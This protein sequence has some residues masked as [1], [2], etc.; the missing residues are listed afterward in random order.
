MMPLC[1]CSIYLCCYAIV[2]CVTFFPLQCSSTPIFK[3]I[4]LLDCCTEKREI[5]LDNIFSPFL[6]LYDRDYKLL[7]TMVYQVD[8]ILPKSSRS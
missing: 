7:Y 4:K 5:V 8:C 2:R 3:Y 6:A 1:I